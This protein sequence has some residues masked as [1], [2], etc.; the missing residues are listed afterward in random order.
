MGVLLQG[1]IGSLY[2][3]YGRS[4]EEKLE[5]MLKRHMIHFIGS[6]V[7]HVKQSSYTRI[8]SVKE[9]VEKLTGSS[10]MAQEL[11]STNIDKVIKDEEIKTYPVRRKVTRVRSLRN[12]IKIN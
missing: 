10:S 7:H 4:A 12:L 3:K 8:Q 6:D 5:E 1:N 2:R 11:V 9:K